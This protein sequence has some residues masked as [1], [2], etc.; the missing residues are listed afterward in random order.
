[1]KHT[2][3]NLVTVLAAQSIE[4]IWFIGDRKAQ[5][6]LQVAKLPRVELPKTEPMQ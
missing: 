6:S 2:I 4:Q 5:H 3:N 1:L